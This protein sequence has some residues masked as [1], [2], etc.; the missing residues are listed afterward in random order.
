MQVTTLA[1]GCWAL[2]GDGTWGEQDDADSIGAVNAALDCGIRFFDTAPAYGGG[3]SEQVLGRALGARRDQA[4]IADKVS[5]SQLKPEQ[6]ATSVEKSLRDLNTDRID[7]LQIHWPARDVPVA[8]TLGAMARL[9]EAGKI[10]AIGVSNFGPHDLAEATGIVPIQSNQV[11]CSLLMRAIEY[12][13]QPACL[14]REVS[15][16]AYGPLAMGLLTGKYAS[17]ADIPAERL[18][19]RYVDRGEADRGG[20]AEAFAAIERIGAIAREA[21]LPMAHVA[22]A[23]CRRRAGVISVIVGGRNATQVRQNAAAAT[24]E[25]GD[26]VVGALDEATEALKRWTGPNAD[27]WSEQSRI[28]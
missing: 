10:R 21:G 19:V 16:L 26:D 5:C 18:R 12:E 17:P 2:S 9:L 7:L 25:L 27:Q 13:I 28:R 11:A 14:D 22:L 15:I 6:V 4:V 20:I 24:V 23:W 8:D 3:R 1:M